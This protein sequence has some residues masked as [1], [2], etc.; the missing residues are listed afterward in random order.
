MGS[1]SVLN[2]GQQGTRGTLEA[3]H[4]RPQDPSAGRP[5]HFWN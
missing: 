1:Q 2:L 5:A 3:Q 4:H